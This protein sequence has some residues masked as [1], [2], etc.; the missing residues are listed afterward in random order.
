MCTIELEKS[1][2]SNLQRGTAP[3]KVEQARGKGKGLERRRLEIMLSI[4]LFD[5]IVGKED[6]RFLLGQLRGT[7]GSKVAAAIT[8]FYL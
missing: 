8:G 6:V 1:P 3:L 4:G 7:K 2:E 5:I